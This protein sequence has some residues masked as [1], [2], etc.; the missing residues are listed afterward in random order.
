MT[1]VLM[2]T[3]STNTTSQMGFFDV[4]SSVPPVITEGTYFKCNGAN[5]YWKDATQLLPIFLE[6]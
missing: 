1:G 5:F 6:Y 4:D 3:I 2:D